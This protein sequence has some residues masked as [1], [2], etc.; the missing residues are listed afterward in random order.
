MFWQRQ[1]ARPTRQV[2]LV[3]YDGAMKL[4]TAHLYDCGW[5]A[6]WHAVDDWW[7]LLKDDGTTLGVSY[8]TR[9]LMADGWPEWD[10]LRKRGSDER[11]QR[12]TA[13]HH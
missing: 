11:S 2:F 10:R 4:T 12:A 1:P 9:W 13:G 7:L 3:R 5:M 8:V 6:Q